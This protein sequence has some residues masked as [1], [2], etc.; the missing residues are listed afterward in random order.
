MNGARALLET[1]V[2]AGVAVCFINPWGSEMQFVAALDTHNR[3]RR[4]PGLFKGVL[5]GVADRQ[6]RMGGRP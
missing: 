2:D 4:L 1:L 3:M 6:A 5:T